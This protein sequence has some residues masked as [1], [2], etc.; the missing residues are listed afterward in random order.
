MLRDCQQCAT[1]GG[2]A[3]DLDLSRTTASQLLHAVVKQQDESS[4][5]DATFCQSE[6]VEEI[7]GE[8]VIPC[9][10]TFFIDTVFYRRSIV[11]QLAMMRV[12]NLDNETSE[13]MT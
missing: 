7:H 4:E 6:L 1:V 3:L 10:G 8:D 2:L 5:Y 11:V 12:E 9:T 13:S